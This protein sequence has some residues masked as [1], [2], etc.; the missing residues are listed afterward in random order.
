MK[1]LRGPLIAPSIV[2]ASC[3]AASSDLPMPPPAPLSRPEAAGIPAVQPRPPDADDIASKTYP[4]SL[5]VS[6]AEQILLKTGVFNF[7]N[8]PGASHRA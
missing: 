1:S 5:T 4:Q 8:S 6:Q 7:H 2:A 3:G